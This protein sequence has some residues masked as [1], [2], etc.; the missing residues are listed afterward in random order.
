MN[1]V[2][3]L[4]VLMV[5]SII[6]FL[7]LDNL[8]QVLNHTMYILQCNR[9]T[10][11]TFHMLNYIRYDYIQH[12]TENPQLRLSYPLSNQGAISFYEILD[13]QKKLVRYRIV[14]SAG[15]KFSLYRETYLT[16]GKSKI[17]LNTRNI[18]LDDSITF[19]LGDDE[20]HVIIRSDTYGDVKLP[21]T[22]PNVVIKN[23]IVK[24]KSD[25]Q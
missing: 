14:R 23:I 16:I 24:A 2:E 6:I 1:F 5:S 17:L 9:I 3:L 19:C 12:S 11:S 25:E 22:P 15:K 8:T 13:G 18:T 4:I 7:A 20:S 10:I 21:M